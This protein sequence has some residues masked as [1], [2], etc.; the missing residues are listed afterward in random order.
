MTTEKSTMAV[1]FMT[2][3][4]AFIGYSLP[5]PIF[6]HLFLSPEYGL[7]GSDTTESYRTMLYGGAVAMYPLGQMVGG[8][9]LGRWSDLYGRK[10]VLQLSLVGTVIGASIMAAGISSLSIP[11][12]FGGYLLAGL[13]EGNVV[14]VQSIASDIS[15]GKNKT[16]NFALIAI[17][18]ELGFVFGPLLGGLLADKTL[19]PWFGAAVPFWA[20]AA[21]MAANLLIVRY[22]LVEP[23]KKAADPLAS[24]SET[25]RRSLRQTLFDPAL[26]P[27]YL[28][29]FFSFVSVFA[30]FSFFAPYLVQVFKVQPGMLGVYTAFS[31]IPMIIIGLVVGRLNDR[32]GA[33]VLGIV[34]HFVL[35]IGLV[36]YVLPE[37]INGLI[38]PFCIAFT[39]AGVVQVATSLYLSNAAPVGEQ[40]QVMGLYRSVMVVAELVIALVG[41]VLAGYAAG[42][43]YLAGA[44]TAVICGLLLLWIFRG[45]TRRRSL[46][47]M[48][49]CA[50][51]P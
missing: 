2:V 30:L 33:G 46:S 6:S 41:G 48:G 19:H 21:L 11:M 51:E 8:P 12:V 49:S 36:L 26:A 18:I 37:T 16:K 43:P 4:T 17:A 1:V 32:V 22:F 42:Y 14:I 15:S 3:L 50:Q 45:Q 40:G 27:F 38:I 34:G 28:V 31:A 47:S 13:C 39:G 9:L 23:K 5:F 7:V 10:K 25:Q 35:A 20:G 44:L 24:Q 29:T